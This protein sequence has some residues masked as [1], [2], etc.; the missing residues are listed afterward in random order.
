MQKALPRN[1]RPSVVGGLYIYARWFDEEIAHSEKIRDLHPEAFQA[2]SNSTLRIFCVL[3]GKR[4][5]KTCKPQRCRG[6]KDT[7]RNFKL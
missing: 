7:Q 3:G 2:D 1:E 5:R 6:R 4:K